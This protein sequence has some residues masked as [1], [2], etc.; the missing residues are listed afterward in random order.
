MDITNMRGDVSRLP[1][2]SPY[3]TLWSIQLHF[4][5]HSPLPS[6][7]TSYT[8]EDT[9]I[10]F[11]SDNGGLGEGKD[12]GSVDYGHNSN[13]SL[14]GQ[15][16]TIYEGGSRIPMIIRHDGTIPPNKTRDSLVGLSDVYAT[17]CDIAGVTI[18][19][20]SSAVDSIS[21]AN[22]LSSK[23]GN[24]A[25]EGASIVRDSFL[26]FDVGRNELQG[27]FVVEG[28]SLRMGKYKLIRL[29]EQLSPQESQSS[30]SWKVKDEL[31]DL[32]KDIGETNN[33]IN[34]VQLNEMVVEMKDKL[35]RDGPCPKETWES[36]TNRHRRFCA[37]NVYPWLDQ[38]GL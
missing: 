35:R 16:G 22:T 30:S 5:I 37:K 31:Y 12:S 23:Y 20:G 11:A 10:I 19:N 14:R 3:W 4:N 21:F 7:C 18:P 27:G 8:A 1:L 33:L 29:Y 6:V 17:I 15:K 13:G 2:P 34:D 9:I 24:S 28:E 25:S 26:T 38:N 36:S 32:D